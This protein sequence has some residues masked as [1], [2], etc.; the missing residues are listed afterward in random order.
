MICTP[1]D[2]C[3]VGPVPEAADK[4]YDERVADNFRLGASAAAE[5]NVDIVAEPGC[6][7][8][9]PTSPELSY[10]TAEVWDVEIA[11]QLNAEQ[12]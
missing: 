10:V 7:G 8:Y 12:L 4:K 6:Q 2:E 9:V 1:G 11:H 3:P 5:R